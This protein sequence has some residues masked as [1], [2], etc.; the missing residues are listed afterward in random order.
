ML[1]RLWDEECQA[2]STELRLATLEAIGGA[3]RIIETHLDETMETL[4]PAERDLA[5]HLFRQFVTPSG[6]KYA[7]TISDLVDLTDLPEAEIGAV[8]DKLARP[9]SQILRAVAPPPGKSDGYR[10]EITHDVLGKAVLDWRRRHEEE[11]K[12]RRVAEA[13]EEAR[14]ANEKHLKERRRARIFRGLMIASLVLLALSI[15]AGVFALRARGQANEEAKRSAS[16]SAAWKA[17]DFLGRN[18]RTKA[19]LLAAVEA[20]R[21]EPTSFEARRAVLSGLHEDP[22]LGGVL[23][24]FSWR[25]TAV[26]FVARIATDRDGQLGRDGSLVQRD[27][28]RFDRHAQPADSKE[29]LPRSDEQT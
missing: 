28:R 23:E 15:A 8:L 1:R 6:T 19:A 5:A 12:D 10:Y 29:R 14:E 26:A 7:H 21:L 27:D 13:E 18:Y 3:Q 16:R 11:D 9:G 24:D 17:S 25:L 20:L 2:G 22:S 4:T